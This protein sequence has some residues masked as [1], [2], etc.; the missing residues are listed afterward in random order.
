MITKLKGRKN[1]AH[2]SSAFQ[3]IEYNPSFIEGISGISGQR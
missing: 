2:I 3:C 1:I